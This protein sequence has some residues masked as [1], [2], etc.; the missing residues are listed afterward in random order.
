MSPGGGAG[1][2]DPYHRPDV[3]KKRVPM[4]AQS[5]RLFVVVLLGWLRPCVRMRAQLFAFLGYIR[6]PP[7]ISGVRV[8]IA[9]P[10]MEKIKG[11]SPKKRP[12][13][14]TR[15]PAGGVPEK[16]KKILI[17]LKKMVFSN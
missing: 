11:S 8:H 3:F 16:N 17:R 13:G 15:P 14:R 7:D 9:C 1:Q 10:C 12:C 4:G 2:V 5:A 6:Q